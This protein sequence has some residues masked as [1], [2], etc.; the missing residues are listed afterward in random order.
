MRN[1]SAVDSISNS[2]D[3]LPTGIEGAGDGGDGFTFLEV[4]VDLVFF[5]L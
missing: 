3:S 4:V 1:F 5:D 2:Y